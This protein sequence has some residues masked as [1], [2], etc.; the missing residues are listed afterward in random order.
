MESKQFIF[1]PHEYRTWSPDTHTLGLNVQTHTSTHAH[2]APMEKYTPTTAGIWHSVSLSRL[3]SCPSFIALNTHT[4][5]H[6]VMD[7]C[8]FVSVFYV[9]CLSTMSLTATILI[10][11]WFLLY[12]WSFQPKMVF[13]ACSSSLHACQ[14]ENRGPIGAEFVNSWDGC[15]HQLPILTSGG[16]RQ[17]LWSLTHSNH[18]PSVLNSD[19][20]DY[21]LCQ[22]P[23]E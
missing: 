3:P 18:I 15:L 12:K 22:K 14:L 11:H 19:I 2:S 8:L 7:W 4:H 21:Q 6:T 17:L 16:N 9:P 1:K 20:T 5:T 10:I 23:E 13:C